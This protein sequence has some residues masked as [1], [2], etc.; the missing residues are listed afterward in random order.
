MP[1]SRFSP[2]QPS[3]SF[4]N[5][6]VF[7]D[8]LIGS[9][10]DA[11]PAAV[12]IKDEDGIYVFINE[13]GAKYFNKKKSEIIGKNDF[14]LFPNEVAVM[15][16]ES[17]KQ[18]LRSSHGTYVLNK[19]NGKNGK[20][21]SYK[22]SKFLIQSPF[23]TSKQAILGVAMDVT[24]LKMVQSKLE[25]KQKLLEQICVLSPNIIFVYNTK[26]Q[27]YVYTNNY[28][29]KVLG[30]TFEE[31]SEA[32]G[33]MFNLIHP[34]EKDDILNKLHEIESN[35]NGEVFE[36]K[37]RYKHKKGHYVWVHSFISTFSRDVETGLVVEILVTMQDITETMELQK[38]LENQARTDELTNLVNRRYFLEIL[39]EKLKEHNS[40]TLLFIDLN[41]FK[42]IN[43]KYGHNA[44][45]AVLV[46]TARRLK[47][48][49]RS[50]HDIIT[51][52]GG[53]EFTVIVQPDLNIEIDNYQA[54]ILKAF[55]PVFA[56]QG[57]KIQIEAS[58]GVVAHNFP[59][60]IT[61]EEILKKADK[62]MYVV[63]NGN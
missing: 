9:V 18:V 6:L 57:I 3:D 49:F 53:D 63:K 30:Y 5:D 34:S 37:Q 26:M 44:G 29:E 31:I 14:D 42:R 22:A 48:V 21:T 51:R 8:S 24:E 38:K 50:K 11:V 36:M 54:R 33:T 43:D 32:G 2:A 47:R 20:T 16:Q 35:K 52:L 13:S 56:Y 1:N 10:I 27:M 46:E 60:T 45:D 19:K 15:T 62:E 17:D 7:D 12:F 41:K 40:F 4:A 55:Y 58:V 39:N 61:A 23:D 28:F 59:T 25:E